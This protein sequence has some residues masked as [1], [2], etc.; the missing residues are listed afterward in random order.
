MATLLDALDQE[1]LDNQREVVKNEKRQSYDNRP[2][3]SFYEKLM[4]AVFPADHPYHHTPIGSM[5]D[6]DAASLEDVIA[7]F[8]TWYAP[9]QRGPLDRRRRRRGAG[10][11]GG[12]A[13]LRADPG[14]SR[15]RQPARGRRRRP[16]CWAPRCAR[17]C[18][19]PCR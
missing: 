1:N 9:E 17:W 7:F 3:G 15:H 5:E 6:L 12:R 19:T 11:R 2:Y 4:A 16:T 13:S 14:Q 8:K 18:R 10:V